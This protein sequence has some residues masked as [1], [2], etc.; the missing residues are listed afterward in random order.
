[1]YKRQAFGWHVQTVDGHDVRAISNAVD[2][3]KKL[4]GKPSMILL[5]TVKGK[6]GYFC[7]NMVASHNMTIDRELSLIHI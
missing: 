1:M 4:K 5:D 7:E 6:G 3:A 2:N